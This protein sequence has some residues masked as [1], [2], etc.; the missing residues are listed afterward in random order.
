M[1]FCHVG[2]TTVKLLTSGGLFTSASQSIGITEKGEAVKKR[3]RAAEEGTASSAR[4]GQQ[5]SGLALSPRLECSGATSTHCSLHL[6]GSCDSPASASGVA[7]ITGAQHHTQLISLFSVQTGLHHIGQLV[8][9]SWPQMTLPLQ[10]PKVL[11]LQTCA[12]TPGQI[13][14]L[15]V[16]MLPI[17]LCCLG[18]SRTPGLWQFSHLSLPKRLRQENCLNLGG[19]GCSEPKLRHCT[20]AWKT[21]QDSV[22]KKKKKRKMA[23]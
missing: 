1:G 12:T 6:L 10:P 2:Q 3:L 14:L 13:V 7:R 21:N 19:K 15:F 16:E 4:P 9:D 17:S 18:W 23:D 5:C 20:P 22:L 8:S 11:G